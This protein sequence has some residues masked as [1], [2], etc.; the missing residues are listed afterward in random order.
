M[1]ALSKLFG[2]SVLEP[3]PVIHACVIHKADQCAM[4]LLDIMDG[5]LALTHI[6]QVSFEEVA[7]LLRTLHF[8]DER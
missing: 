4:P 6:A 5:F 1:Q 7:S 8:S 3:N 2:R